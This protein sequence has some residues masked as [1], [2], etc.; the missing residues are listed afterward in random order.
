MLDR[1]RLRRIWDYCNKSLYSPLNYTYFM[2]YIL[3]IVISDSRWK[4]TA[5]T[6]CWNSDRS[7]CGQDHQWREGGGDGRE[8]AAGD[9]IRTQNFLFWLAEHYRSKEPKN[10]LHILQYLWNLYLNFRRP[11]WPI[12]ELRGP[13][14]NQI[15]YFKAVELSVHRP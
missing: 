10:H 9:E 3:L 7:I 5:S 15:D 4:R 12:F 6:R 13:L 11:H 14:F 8:H 1:D 2:H